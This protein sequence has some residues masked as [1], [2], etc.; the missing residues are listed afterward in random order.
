MQFVEKLKETISSKKSVAMGQD[1]FVKEFLEIYE[2]R[3]L[4]VIQTDGG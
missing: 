2:G 4:I 1:T 3:A